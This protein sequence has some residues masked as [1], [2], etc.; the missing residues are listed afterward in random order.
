[1]IFWQQ[2]KKQRPEDSLSSGLCGYGFVWEI[3]RYWKRTQDE[4]YFR[5]RRNMHMQPGMYIIIAI[6]MLF[7]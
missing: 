3:S 6:I 4:S 7:V 2:K 1:M 5:A